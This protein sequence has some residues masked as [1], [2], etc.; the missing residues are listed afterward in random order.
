MKPNT[1]GLQ[2]PQ[3]DDTDSAPKAV[4]TEPSTSCVVCHGSTAAPVRAPCLARAEDD[5]RRT[6][7][8]AAGDLREAPNA[9]R[10]EL[11]V[12]LKARARERAGYL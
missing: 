12:I 7:R 8:I 3:H 9:T 11:D 2:S 6:A 5:R 4:P 1:Y 10:E